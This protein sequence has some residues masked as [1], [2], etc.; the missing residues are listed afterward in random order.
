MP[1][2]SWFHGITEAGVG[3]DAVLLYAPVG[4]V[5]AGSGSDLLTLLNQIALADQVVGVN[6]LT[7]IITPRARRRR[8]VFRCGVR[9]RGALSLEARIA[10][11]DLDPRSTPCRCRGSW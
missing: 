1:S 11:S 7:K 9:N 6:T 8:S 5:D 4:V 10:L 2:Q 3:S